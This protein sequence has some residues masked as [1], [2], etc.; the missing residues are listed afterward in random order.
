LIPLHELLDRIRWDAEFAKA[1][2]TLA[3]FDRVLGEL[4]YVPL[5]SMSYDRTDDV[6]F[7]IVDDEGQERSIPF[8]RVKRVLRNGELIWHREH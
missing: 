1:E 5:K 8:H 3:Y 2:F 7:R 6:R 4:I